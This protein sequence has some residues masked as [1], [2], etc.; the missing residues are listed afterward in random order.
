LPG[1]QPMGFIRTT[2]L[3]VGGSFVGG[4]IASLLYGHPIWHLHPSGF[5]G[6]VIGSVLLLVL[7]GRE[8]SRT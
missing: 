5:I 8:R 2:L 4:A 1:D 7:F 3:G 6:A